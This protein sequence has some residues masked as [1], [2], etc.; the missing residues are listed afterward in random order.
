MKVKTILIS[1]AILFLALSTG[2]LNAQ[3]KIGDNP[4]TKDPSSI[5]ELEIADMGLLIPRISL[6]DATDNTTIATPANSLLVY[7][8][9]TGGSDGD[10]VTPGFYYWS[11]N[12]SR[13]IRLLAGTG[14]AYSTTIGSDAGSGNVG[15]QVLLIGKESGMYNMGDHVTAFGD[16]TART[17]Q[18]NDVNAMGTFCAYGNGSSGY[19]LNAFGVYA[20]A[21]NN[22][23]NVNA[24]GASA[25]QNNQG[26]NLNAIGQSA[27]ANN[28]GQHVNALGFESAY[29]NDGSHAVAVGYR[30]LMGNSTGTEGEGN[31]GIGYQS[32][33]NIGD[34]AYNIAIG[35]DT[36]F[37]DGDASNQIN[38]GNS[39]IRDADGVIQLSDLI[40]LPPTSAPSNP[41]PGMIYF[42]SS[43][44]IL[45]CYDGSIWQAL[46]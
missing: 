23:P 42:D 14:N 17:N 1:L 10:E 28:T 7:N 8:E 30:A 15:A 29:Y 20:A 32:G 34:G 24:L 13:W 39:I 2:N 21:S 46:W 38:I 44:N 40:M 3:V 6:T 9:N 25:A 11:D 31:I 41:Q 35:Y 18:A 12:D 5:L 16:N 22:A 26:G 27:G 19:S 33:M 4:E 45:Y 36:E 43:D 37:P